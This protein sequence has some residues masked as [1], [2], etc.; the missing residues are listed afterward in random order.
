MSGAGEFSRAVL[1]VTEKTDFKKRSNE[2]NGEKPEGS[3]T[4]RLAAL[5]AV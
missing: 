2:A 4:G 1:E 5:R 3:L